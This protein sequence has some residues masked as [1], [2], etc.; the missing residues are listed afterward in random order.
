MPTIASGPGRSPSA[1]DTSTGTAT[2]QTAVV[3]A[4]TAIRP[5]ARAR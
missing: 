4:T 3:G 2:A 1:T 5:I